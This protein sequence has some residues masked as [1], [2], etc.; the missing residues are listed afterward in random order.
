MKKASCEGEVIELPMENFVDE[1]NMW[2]QAVQCELQEKSM[3][4]TII[5]CAAT[6]DTQLEKLIKNIL[7][8]EKNT[9]DDIFE[10]G[11]APLSTFSS[12]IIL[13]YYLGLISEHERKTLDCIRKIR[14]KAAHE[15][16]ILSGRVSDS[17][18]NMCLNLEIPQGMYVPIELFCGNPSGGDKMYNPN[19]EKSPQKRFVNAF[20]YMT[21]YLFFHNLEYIDFK[22]EKYQAPKPFE[23]IEM[24]RNAL[25]NDNERI[26][27][28]LKRCKEKAQKDLCE[29]QTFARDYVSGDVIAY[30]QENLDSKE[31]ILEA[32][33]IVADELKAFELEISLRESEN[34]PSDSDSNYSQTCHSIQLLERLI[35][36]M[37]E[38]Q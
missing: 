29:L 25:V 3:R 9:D 19:E 33:G 32:I 11:N 5:I 26:L 21:Q 35:E 4:S 2:M 23:F 31:K 37:K 28:Y 12:K 30:R 20:Y 27:L 17:I 8:Q 6:L 10:G 38:Y 1:F 18:N 7:L 16:D 36:V 24:F 34:I 22:V 13:A 15:I 14:N